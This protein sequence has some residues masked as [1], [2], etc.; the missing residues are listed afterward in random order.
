M[1]TENFFRIKLN[2][3][4]FPQSQYFDHPESLVG[5]L[6]HSYTL[7]LRATCLCSVNCPEMYIAHRNGSYYFAKMPETGPFHHLGCEFYQSPESET[8]RA[9]YAKGVI[10]DAGGMLDVKIGIPF[11]IHREVMKTDPS[12]PSNNKAGVKRSAIELLGLI[13][14]LWEFSNNAK[15]F[16]QRKGKVHYTRSWSSAHYFL[17]KT[18]ERITAKGKP[19]SQNLYIVPPYNPTQADNVA[20]EFAKFIAPVIQA[21]T[22]KAQ[23]N[24]D[25]IVCKLILGEVRDITPSKY[26]FVVRI[27][28]LAQP[29]YISENRFDRVRN[30]YH[31]ACNAI[32]SEH[33]SAIAIASVTS[34]SSGNLTVEKMALMPVSKAYIPFE[35][36]FELKIS[37]MLIEQGRCFEKPMRYDSEA[38]TLPDFIL[39]DAEYPRMPFEIYG[40]TGNSDYDIRK[41]QKRELYKSSNIPCWEW[42][43]ALQIEP[44]PFP[45]KRQQNNEEI[46]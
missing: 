19:L 15:W 9:S 32:E 41:N 34:T 28:N 42:E 29:L 26:G 17:N 39:C 1:G 40:M 10:E 11:K 33:A 12:P 6:Q 22:V 20:Q 23:Q 21:G 2:G 36:S 35:S 30:S 37:Q 3:R 16:P 13:H 46:E 27:K 31:L 24:K 44:P 45:R 4:V 18:T 25:D 7:G 43:P 14:L 8:G 38:L 5:L